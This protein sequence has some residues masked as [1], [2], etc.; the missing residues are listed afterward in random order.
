[1][2]PIRDISNLPPEFRRAERNEAQKRVEDSRK[3]ATEKLPQDA[4]KAVGQ[5]KVS[6][7]DTARTM[8][9]RGDEVKHYAKDLD[10]IDPISAEEIK[11]IEDKIGAGF[12]SSPEVL[13]T[14]AAAISK[15]P[16]ITAST[17]TPERLQEIVGNIRD[18]KYDD[19]DVIGTIAD[20]IINDL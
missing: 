18:G 16:G 9:E 7:S 11:A 6:L 4:A 15:T 20:R 2:G 1:M 8:L 13:E 5:D 3:E 19:D 17:I 12:Y 14:I 10:K